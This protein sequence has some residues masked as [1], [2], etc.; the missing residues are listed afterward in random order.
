MFLCIQVIIFLDVQMLYVGVICSLTY[1]TVESHHEGGKHSSPPLP[2]LLSLLSGSRWRRHQATHVPLAMIIFCLL[3]LSTTFPPCPTPKWEHFRATF[4]VAANFL[5]KQKA[6]GSIFKF[7]E[8]K[9]YFHNRNE[10]YIFWMEIGNKH[11]HLFKKTDT[12][13][14]VHAFFATTQEGL[15]IAPPH[16]MHFDHCPQKNW[17]SPCNAP[18]QKLLPRTSLILY[19]IF[20]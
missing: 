11:K 20:I 9:N 5:G 14:M 18:K 12:L 13:W 17:L 10:N 1:L 19:I 3:F 16:H 7:S 15:T 6:S 8:G 2:H 4:I